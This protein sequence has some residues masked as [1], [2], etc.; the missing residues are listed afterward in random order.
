MATMYNLEN[1]RLQNDNLIVQN[2]V[3]AEE[4]ALKKAMVLSTLQDVDR[5]KFD[6]GLDQDLREYDAQFRKETLRQKQIEN[7]MKL[8]EYEWRQVLNTSSLTEAA[9]RILSHRASR[10]NTV[11]Q[12]KV[13]QQQY[14]NLIKDGKIKQFEI[15]LNKS[16]L[17]RSDS[18]KAR[19][20]GLMLSQS[21]AHEA[22]IKPAKIIWNN[23]KDFWKELTDPAKGSGGS[24]W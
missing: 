12:R 24:S 5:K 19:F 16:G 8:N 10:A 6:L 3:K 21:G 9:E 22:A 15:D 20:L 17:T 1:M 4:A 13:I 18:A 7:Q 23:V 2:T 14:K 11:E